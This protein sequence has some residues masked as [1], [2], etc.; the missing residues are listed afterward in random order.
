MRV[1][2]SAA[3]V[4]DLKAIA[5]WIEQDR[6]LDTANRITRAIY[7]AVQELRTMPYRGRYGRL[8]DTR[9]L[10]IPQLPYI[11]V[12]HVVGERLLILDV[13]HAAQRWP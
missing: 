1:D 11:I 12:Y 10:V 13:L 3:A 9:E 5:E 8:G 6:G 7:N 2:W 4:A